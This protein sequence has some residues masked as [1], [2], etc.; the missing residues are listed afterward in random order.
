MFVLIEGNFFLMRT[1]RWIFYIPW[2]VRRLKSVKPSL[3][4]S[5][6]KRGSNPIFFTNV[7]SQYHRVKK[8]IL[9]VALSTSWG[10]NLSKYL[11]NITEASN[12]HGQPYYLT[13][14]YQKFFKSG[15]I[16]I[17]WDVM[18]T[19]KAWLPSDR[20]NICLHGFVMFCTFARSCEWC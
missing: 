18:S 6:L 5:F 11:R 13:G 19:L 4:E 16:W 7:F 8:K 15:T 17:Y 10:K 12:H 1:R 20:L 2:K 3:I 14:I 9:R